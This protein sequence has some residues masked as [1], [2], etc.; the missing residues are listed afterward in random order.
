MTAQLTC[1]SPE[2]EDVCRRLHRVRP[3]VFRPVPRDAICTREYGGPQ[4]ARIRGTIGRRR[5]D[6]RFNRSGGCEI[7]RYDAVRFLLDLAR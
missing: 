3:S 1:P 7:A 2:R 6:A 4:T 5:V